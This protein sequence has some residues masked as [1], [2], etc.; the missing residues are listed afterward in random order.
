MP[1]VLR[2]GRMRVM[3]Y[4]NDHRPAHAHVWDSGRQ[5]VFNFHCPDGPL[6]LRESYGFSWPESKSAG[7]LIAE[8]YSGP[9]RRME[10]D[11]WQLIESNSKQPTREAW[12]R[13]RAGLLR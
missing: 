2:F 10:G 7:Q 11:S 8:T 9:M 6:E 5:V 4:I 12:R 13:L 1:T 3:I